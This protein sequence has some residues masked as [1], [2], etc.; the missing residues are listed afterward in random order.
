MCLTGLGMFRQDIVVNKLEPRYGRKSGGMTLTIF[1]QNFG[2]KAW[3]DGA[4]RFYT[5][6]NTMSG[7]RAS[8]PAVRVDNQICTRAWVEIEQ[9][10]VKRIIRPMLAGSADEH[11]CEILIHIYRHL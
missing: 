3:I 8:E 10:Q 11:R 4:F 6:A 2:R 1:G 7:L 5:S 9:T